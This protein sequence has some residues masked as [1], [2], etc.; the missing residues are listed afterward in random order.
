MLAI[1]IVNYKSERETISFV[2]QEL[3]KVQTPHTIVIVNNMASEQSNKILVDGLGAEIISEITVKP[4]IKNNIFI[5]PHLENLG[6]AKGN[7]LGVAFSLLHFNI[8]NLLF[9]NNDI[10]FI[11]NNVVERLIEILNDKQD[12]G[13]I[14]PRI[15]GL[16]DKNQSPEP[17]YSFWFRYV[18]RLWA[19]LFLSDKR[20]REFLKL[21]YSQNAKEGEHYKVMGSFFIIKAAD[22]EKCKMMDSHTFLFA[23]EVILSERLNSIGKSVYYYP[24]VAVLHEHG[25]IISAHL[26]DKRKSLVQFASECY[27]YRAYKKISS[28][29]IFI[30]SISFYIYLKIRKFKH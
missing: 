14:G 23:E 6:Y 24:E 30:G 19:G 26:N 21:D 16:D 13:L 20:K 17:Y 3:C 4:G 10:R 27:Y 12:V 22:F 28:F 25:Q 2:K 29:S 7:N 1:I 11:D 5:L 8:T 15:I 18:W 9:S